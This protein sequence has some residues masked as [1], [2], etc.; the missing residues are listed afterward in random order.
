MGK[1]NIQTISKIINNKSVKMISGSYCP[2][3]PSVKIFLADNLRQPIRESSTNGLG[4]KFNDI[5][6]LPPIDKNPEF[7]KFD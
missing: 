6:I 5:L 3:K 1:K 2:N 7:P 4:N